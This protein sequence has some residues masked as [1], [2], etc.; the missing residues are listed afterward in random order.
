MM[1][2]TSRAEITDSVRLSYLDSR[3]HIPEYFPHIQMEK[4]YLYLSLPLLLNG[5]IFNVL[6]NCSEVI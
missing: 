2:V 6:I 5:L 3:I 4:N 1:L